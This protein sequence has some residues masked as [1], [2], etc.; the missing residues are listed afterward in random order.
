MPV[1][2]IPLALTA[3]LYPFRLAVLLLLAEA[4]RYKGGVTV[5]LARADICMLAIGFAIVLAL[6]GAGLG[7]QGRQ[8]PRYGLRLGIWR[9]V[10][11]RGSSAGSPAA[12]AEEERSI[13]GDSPL[14]KAA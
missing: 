10:R 5:F 9:R 13:E 8:S 4:E 11:G 6:H 2:A 14:K 1:Q 7:Q 12:E 3:G